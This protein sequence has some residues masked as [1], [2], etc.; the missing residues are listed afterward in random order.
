M[1]CVLCAI[2]GDKVVDRNVGDLTVSQ[3][4]NVL[5]EELTLECVWVIVVDLR[6][7]F[8]GEG[9]L[10]LVVRVVLEDMGASLWESICQLTRDGRFSAARSTGDAYNKTLKWGHISLTSK[11]GEA[12]VP[13]QVERRLALTCRP[14]KT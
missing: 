12:R 8:V 9:A 14:L 1:P 11:L 7:R 10:I 2:V 6:A 4:F 3:E 13:R 5:C